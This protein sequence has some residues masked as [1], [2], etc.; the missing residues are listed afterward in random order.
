MEPAGVIQ[1]DRSDG[2]ARRR[3]ARVFSRA[4]GIVGLAG[5]TRTYVAATRSSWRCVARVGVQR[6]VGPSLTPILAYG[7]W[8]L[9]ES[10]IALWVYPEFLKKVGH[11]L[12]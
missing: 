7:I 8:F 9:S 6:R 3:I 12:L 2:R 4:G 5:F 11:D 10:G 1:M